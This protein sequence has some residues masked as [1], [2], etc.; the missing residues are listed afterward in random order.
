MPNRVQ[1]IKRNIKKE[2]RTH[3]Y[4]T[5]SCSLVSSSEA[6]VHFCTSPWWSRREVRPVFCH[7]ADF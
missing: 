3:T 5:V 1:I 4:H 2:M 7:R 6:L